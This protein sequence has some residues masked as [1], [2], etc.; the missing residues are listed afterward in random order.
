[1]KVYIAGDDPLTTEMFKKRGWDVTDYI[2]KADLVQFTGGSDVDPSIYGEHTHPKTYTSKLR[3]YNDAWQFN[4]AYRLKIPMAGICRGGQFL[5][6]F[7]GG[8]LYQHVD[9][10]AIGSKHPIYDVK[11]GKEIQATS[12]H[13]QMMRPGEGA[14]L[15]ATAGWRATRKEFMVEDAVAHSMLTDPDTE[16]V[17]YNKAAPAL[18]FQPHP[19][20]VDK[21]DELQDY[22]FELLHSY[23]GVKAG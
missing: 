23:L 5:N 19:E 16:V 13:H 6:V 22:Y 20:F 9:R 15:V 17:F 10:H 18:C 21:D 7:N 11:T 4:K 2:K 8:K 12:T 1:M 3:D 14:E